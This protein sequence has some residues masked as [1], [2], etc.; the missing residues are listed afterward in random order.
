MIGLL[1]RFLERLKVGGS[2][3]KRASSVGDPFTQKIQAGLYILGY[4]HR[5]ME[6]LLTRGQ[7]NLSDK[8]QRALGSDLSLELVN[9]IVARDFPRY[10]RYSFIA[11]LVS[12]AET[13][14]EELCIEVGRRKSLS[15]E[16]VKGSLSGLG[17]VKKTKDFLKKNL[18]EDFSGNT[19]QGFLQSMDKLYGP[20]LFLVRVR[21]CVLHSGGNISKS[22]SGGDQEELKKRINKYAGFRID[23]QF[24]VLE[25]EFCKVAAKK[26]QNL[27]SN[28]FTIL[29]SGTG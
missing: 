1:R 28:L 5:D 18:R 8:I 2:Q 21:N 12:F 15:E 3:L 11:L 22:R 24:I 19:R 6:R 4:Y 16:E 25:E 20:V 29:P 14:L 9:P 7:Q 13:Q 17:K 26:V 23:N 10:L 27:F